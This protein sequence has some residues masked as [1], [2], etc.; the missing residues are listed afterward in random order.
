MLELW[1][2]ADG[3]SFV[4]RRR[5]RKVSRGAGREPMHAFGGDS[6]RDVWRVAAH[7]RRFAAA[8]TIAQLSA[9]VQSSARR[10]HVD[11]MIF[12]QGA[13]P[14]SLHSAGYMCP[15]LVKAHISPLT[16]ALACSAG[17]GSLRFRRLDRR[18]TYHIGALSEL[19]A[20]RS[21]A[22]AI[23][24][25]EARESQRLRWPDCASEARLF[26]SLSV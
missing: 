3:C 19:R 16:L 9:R 10:G 24:A 22:R 2:S 26:L 25:A 18:S 13:L 23:A 17:C 1:H 8:D 15:A 5:P 20:P 14:P 11:K 7:V 4:H 6:F 12:G 21:A